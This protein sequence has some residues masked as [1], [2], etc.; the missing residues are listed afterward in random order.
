M[1]S[2]LRFMIRNSRWD[3][4]ENSVYKVHIWS[5]KRVGL[6]R[7][8]DFPDRATEWRTQEKFPCWAGYRYVRDSAKGIELIDYLAGWRIF[9]VQVPLGM[10]RKVRRWWLEKNKLQVKIPKVVQGSLR[11]RASQWWWQ[12]VRGDRRRGA[13]PP[14]HREAA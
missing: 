4:R 11:G 13:R 9:G 2:V 8:G 6:T 1:M 10:I 12:R 3:S 14:V 5:Q 7:F